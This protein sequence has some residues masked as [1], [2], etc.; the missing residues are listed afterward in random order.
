MSLR[1][2][3]A[4]FAALSFALIALCLTGCGD[5]LGLVPVSGTVT[6][7]DK[8]LSGAEIIFR[9]VDGRPS[10]G[11]TDA[12]G[13]YTLR[14]LDDQNGAVP[15]KHQVSIST[16]GD[17]AVSGGEDGNTKKVERVP[18]QYNSKSTLEV[19][20]SSSNTG[21]TDFKLQSTGVATGS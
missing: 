17:A 6:L 8:P 12:E 19:E 7:D 18:A 5:G 9:P 4:P 14:Y 10:L 21:P 13:K 2:R 20:V 3:L 1:I 15:G 11:V 16:A